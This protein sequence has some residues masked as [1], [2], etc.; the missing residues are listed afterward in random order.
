MDT[1]QGQGLRANRERRRHDQ[2]R[3]DENGRARGQWKVRDRLGDG[4]EGNGMGRGAVKKK[5]RD[6]WTVKKEGTVK[7]GGAVEGK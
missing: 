4:V 3:V 1:A 6:Q 2:D 7:K 5:G